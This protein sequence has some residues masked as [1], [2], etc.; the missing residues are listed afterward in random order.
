MAGGS[1]GVSFLCAF[2]DPVTP[3]PPFGFFFD[4]RSRNFRGCD[5]GFFGCFFFVFIGVV[6]FA[7]PLQRIREQFV[8]STV[9]SRAF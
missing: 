1:V 7:T 5:W 9:P 2:P 8:L 4:C 6:G 3:T